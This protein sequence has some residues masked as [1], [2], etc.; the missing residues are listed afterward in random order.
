MVFPV[1]YIAGKRLLEDTFARE[2]GESGVR[3]ACTEP[4]P[5]PGTIIG[6]QLFLPGG[7]TCAATGVVV[8]ESGPDA[9][10]AETSRWARDGA[11]ERR[12]FWAEFTGVTGGSDAIV[13]ALLGTGQR[14]S[15]RPAVSFKVSCRVGERLVYES[16]LNVSPGGVF[17]RA[18]SSPAVD[19]II[20]AHLELPDGRPPV[21]VRGR[22]AHAS[23][24]GFGLQFVDGEPGFRGRVEA[25]VA[26]LCA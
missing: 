13:A 26:R 7:V 15:R 21:Q 8:E 6:M 5:P 24:H 16:A 14:S 22:V 10:P 19:A 4:P 11:P 12:S 18:R 25:L 1:R 2:L 23:P 9:T 20:D 3:L 17:V